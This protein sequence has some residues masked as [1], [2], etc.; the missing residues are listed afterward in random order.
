MLLDPARVLWCAVVVDVAMGL[1]GD[2]RALTDSGIA[3]ADGG[4]LG[5]A[6]ERFQQAL[7]LDR[8]NPRY[9]S[10]VGVAL[11]RLGRL[12]EAREALEESLRLAPG[13]ATTLENLEAL[14]HFETQSRGRT[15]QSAESKSSVEVGVEGTSN[16]DTM[17][18]PWFRNATLR[19][20][21][22]EHVRSGG[23]AQIRG[24]LDEAFAEAL[25]AE[26]Y[27]ATGYRRVQSFSRFYQFRFLMLDSFEA[28]SAL[29]RAADMFDSA[30]LKDWA[31]E[32]LGLT[33]GSAYF[34]QRTV[35]HGTHYGPGDYTMIHS[36]GTGARRVSYV[37]HLTADWNVEDGGDLVF[38]DPM[39]H[40]HP[41][42]NAMT[43]FATSSVSW[44]F[45]SPVRDP[46][47]RPGNKRLAF[48]GWFMSSFD[49]PSHVRNIMHASQNADN[50][51]RKE[52]NFAVDGAH[53]RELSFDA[54][55]D[56]LDA[57]LRWRSFQ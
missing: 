26:L 37:L 47:V 27:E 46:P 52:R 32:L 44:H 6:L 20:R 30:I 8:T 36:D 28:D 51:K 33:N 22:A 48:S 25:Q 23:V 1:D 57:S 42:M 49:F 9:W 3:M 13:S 11:M 14:E 18:G 15:V 34:N 53:N 56:N 4:N 24:F 21:V 31:G 29:G 54:Y 45:V 12:W 16:Y 43:L 40:F 19:R 50:N 41:A 38:C 35:A 55:Y 17:L 10:N 2:G 7:G 5:G 39:S